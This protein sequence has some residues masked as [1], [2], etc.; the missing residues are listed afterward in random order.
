MKAWKGNGRGVASLRIFG[1]IVVL[2]GFGRVAAKAG[3]SPLDDEIALHVRQFRSKDG[4]AVS[5]AIRG[6]YRRLA[7]SR[8]EAV[9][10]DFAKA[11]GEALQQVL[12][13]QGQTG[14]SYLRRLLF[15]DAAHTSACRVPGVLA[16]TQPESRVVR[17]CSSWFREA[18]ELN[19]AKA[20]AVIIHES[21]HS[22]GLGENPPRSQEITARVMARCGG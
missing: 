4:F 14:Q 13:E 5:Q 18:F 9:F 19:P 7:D 16:F 20:E 2:L 17:V 3:D 12:D 11:S 21:L 8:C 10:S 15:Y 6:A 1:A 22:L